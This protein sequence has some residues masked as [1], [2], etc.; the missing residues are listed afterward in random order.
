MYF[1]ANVVLDLLVSMFVY[2]LICFYFYF[3]LMFCLVK[4]K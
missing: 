2:I 1:R 3:Y 4:K